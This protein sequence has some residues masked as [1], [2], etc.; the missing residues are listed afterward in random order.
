MQNMHSPP[1][2]QRRVHGQAMYLLKTEI[3]QILKLQP[4]FTERAAK[5]DQRYVSCLKNIIMNLVLSLLSSFQNL[6]LLG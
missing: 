4:K 1:F 3:S 2:T 5:G 6:N